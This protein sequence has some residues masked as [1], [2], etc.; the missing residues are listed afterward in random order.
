MTPTEFV[1]A[2]AEFTDNID[3]KVL[4][5]TA[6]DVALAAIIEAAQH[7]IPAERMQPR[8]TVTATT[9]GTQPAA[10]QPGDVVKFTAS[11]VIGTTFQATLPPLELQPGDVVRGPFAENIGTA[12]NEA[13][14]MSNTARTRE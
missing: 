3:G 8:E 10:L 11:D 7:V 6:P 14:G 4:A 5:K 12:R 13:L 9:F 2:V 1:K